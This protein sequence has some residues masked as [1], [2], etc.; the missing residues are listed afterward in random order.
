M[1]KSTDNEGDDGEE[2][3]QRLADQVLGWAEDAIYW[4]IA[5]VL[6]FGSAALLVAQF[7]TLL[8]LRNTSA[9]T[10][11][12]ELLDGEPGVL[13][14]PPGVILVLRRQRFER[15]VACPQ[16]A[17]ALELVVRAGSEVSPRV[18]G[19]RVAN[20]QLLDAMADGRRRFRLEC[21]KVAP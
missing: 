1:A 6:V 5:V 18:V 14:C 19:H 10:L 3:R 21:R 17:D 8:R 7:N 9:S 2:E 12:L 20:D 16:P 15:V 4:G 13:G 11:M